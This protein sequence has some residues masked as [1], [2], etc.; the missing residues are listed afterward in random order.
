[1]LLTTLNNILVLCLFDNIIEV[2]VNQTSRKESLSCEN[3]T[4][5]DL[6]R[7]LYPMCL[8]STNRNIVLVYTNF[9]VI[10]LY[11]WFET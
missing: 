1:M 10:N 7:E 2:K 6:R 8:V 4:Q 11:I 5:K 9:R 3:M